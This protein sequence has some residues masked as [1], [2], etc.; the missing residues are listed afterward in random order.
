M[1]TKEVF[2]LRMND[3]E[4]REKVTTALLDEGY[5][6]NIERKPGGGGSNSITPVHMN[7]WIIISIEVKD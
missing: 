7:Y 6:V 5:I 1:K 2:R 4:A 3:F